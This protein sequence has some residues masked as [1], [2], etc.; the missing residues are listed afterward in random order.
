[1]RQTRRV[2]LAPTKIMLSLEYN[3]ESKA[4]TGLS[5]LSLYTLLPLIV[6]TTSLRMTHSALSKLIDKDI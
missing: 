4:S 2:L 3:S 1:M 6:A 5:S